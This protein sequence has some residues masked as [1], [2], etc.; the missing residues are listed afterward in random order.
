MIYTKGKVGNYMG[1]NHNLSVVSSHP[2]RQSTDHSTIFDDVFRTIAQKMPQLLIP[3][4]NEVFQTHY[5]EDEHFEQLRNEHYE[6]FGK[7]ITDSIIKIGRHYYHLECQSTKDGKMSIRLFEYDVSIALEQAKSTDGMWHIRFPHT[8]VLYIRN[9]RTIPDSH[10]AIVEFADGQTVTYRVPIIKA[11]DYTVNSIFEKRLL[12]LLPYHILR[13]EHFL[14]H[15]RNNTEKLQQLLDD[16]REINQKLA[17]ACQTEQKSELY[18]N[19]I[20]LIDQ[21]ADYIIPVDH[22]VRKG[23][24]KIMGG[25]ILQLESERLRA[26]GRC[27]AIQNMIK[28]NVPKETILQDYTL[29]EYEN[30]VKKK[31][32]K[33]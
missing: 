9:H 1:N 18:V 30:A 3:L 10:T 16:F 29:E 27:E 28:Y 33:I 32:V 11:Q 15:H 14:K 21:I 20:V 8:C 6:K 17:T 25:Q 5:N 24:G 19:M 22:S 31:P 12:I 26:E 13:Y 23:L 7:I 4:I 2:A